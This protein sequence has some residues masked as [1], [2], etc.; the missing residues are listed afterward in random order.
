MSPVYV[1]GVEQVVAH[2]A[3]HQDTGADE[4]SVAALSGALADRQ[5]SKSGDATLGWTDEKLLK[6]AGAGVAPDEIAVPSAGKTYTSGYYDGDGTANRAIAHGLG[7]LPTAVF[8]LQSGGA[9]PGYS[10]Q[11]M[12]LGY[13]TP[14]VSDNQGVSSTRAVTNWDATNFYVGNSANYQDSANYLN[15]DYYWV[16]FR[17]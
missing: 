12:R 4:I 9:Y 2:A 15:D 5:L 8:I 16:A 6:G 1:Q 17:P 3:K 10:Y 13:I 7:V 14:I 11:M